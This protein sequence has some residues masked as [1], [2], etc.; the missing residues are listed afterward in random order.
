MTLSDIEPVARESTAGI[1]AR[2]L[3]TAIM[4]GALAPGTQLTEAELAA[5]FE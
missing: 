5:H 3:R 2:Q 4:T 1:I